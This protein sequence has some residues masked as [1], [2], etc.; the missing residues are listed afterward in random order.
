MLLIQAGSFQM[1]SD[2]GAGD[3]RP[4]HA[5]SLDAFYMDETEVTNS[6]YGAC[7]KDGACPAPINAGSF[8]RPTYFDDPA[9]ANYPVTSVRWDQ[10]AAFCQWNE[11]KRLPTEAEWEYA[12]TGGD[13]RTF[14]WGDTFDLQRLPA[15]EPDTVAVGSYRNGA[16]PFGMLDMA[17][18][19]VEWVSDFYD[20]TYYARAEPNNPPGPAEGNEHVTRGGAFGNLDASFYT[21]TRRYHLALNATDVDVGFRCAKAP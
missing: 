7:V 16:S 1:G 18:N 2:K 20:A 15:G 11:G 10:A 17:G 5:V 3:E 19:A 6:A 8:T 4:T 14:P 9:F 21:T 12:A 13:G